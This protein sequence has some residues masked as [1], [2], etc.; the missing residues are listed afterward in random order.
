MTERARQRVV[1]PGRSFL[2]LNLAL[3]ISL[4]LFRWGSVSFSVA[5]PVDLL[6]ASNGRADE[7]TCINCHVQAEQ[8]H[9][10]GHAQALSRA[11]SP[12]SLKLLA[13]LGDSDQARDEGTIVDIRFDIPHARNSS[14]GSASEVTLD[15]CFG[16]GRHARTWV[17]TL[18]DSQG[19]TDLNEF[20]WTWYREVNGF[21][22]TPGQPDKHFDTHLGPF[23]VLYDH[24]KARRCFACHTSHLPIDDGRLR[25]EDVETGVN[26]QRCHG[27]RAD[28]IASDGEIRDDFWKTAS[29]AEAV[30]RCAQCHR[31]PEEVEV[32]EIRADNPELARF[33]PI[34]LV[35]SKCFTA[36]KNLT[37]TTCHDPHLP[38]E[39]QDSLGDWQCL[40][41]H[42]TSQPEHRLCGAGQ[43][44]DCLQCHMPKVR[45]VDPI[46][47]TDHWIRVR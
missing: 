13:R 39:A 5:P 14:D 2:A 44:D 16:S 36:S 31:R 8:F 47:F 27:P 24:P 23:G 41:C 7:R 28:H 9:A 21:D 34:G 46:R 35:Q 38:L 18:G 15:W 33:Q 11:S 17:T 30:D 1:T 20:R 37:C 26:C 3:V 22:V 42:S 19:A 40:Q 32:D 4:T 6:Q 25:L 10:T 45:S 43:G 29:P 12:D